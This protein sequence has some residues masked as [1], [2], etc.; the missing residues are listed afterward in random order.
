M[1]LYRILNVFQA[2]EQSLTGG[3]VGSF[4]KTRWIINREPPQIN[5][6]FASAILNPDVAK[7]GGKV[8]LIA[9]RP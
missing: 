7:A 8:R 2:F 1:I 3:L 9:D 5:A 6:F 4:N